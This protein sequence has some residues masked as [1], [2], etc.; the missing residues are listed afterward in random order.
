MPLAAPQMVEDVCMT[1][2]CEDVRRLRVGKQ[3]R[4]SQPIDFSSI[5]LPPVH[6]QSPP[7]LPTVK[8]A[9]E[10]LPVPAP[11]P[12]QRWDW[13]NDSLHALNSQLRKASN[14]NK[15]WADSTEMLL[16]QV[17]L[18][19]ADKDKAYGAHKITA[20]LVATTFGLVNVV[21]FLCKAGVDIN[22]ADAFGCTPL[23]LAVKDY[24]T[25]SYRYV[26]SSNF[27][28]MLLNVGA[29]IY[30]PTKS[31]QTPLHWAAMK[32]SEDCMRH[33]L[34]GVVDT[35]IVDKHGRTA[36]HYAVVHAWPRENCA[37]AP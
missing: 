20:L 16:Q 12:K 25:F 15:R 3:Q 17:I 9:P 2:V 7:S 24:G 19:G 33:L 26:D 13:S 31:G 28:L 30:M 29:D 8:A 36:L 32:T 14:G 23:H 34:K 35:D 5:S 27:L 18:A 37:D 21:D 22:K 11:P 10:N 6:F 4:T 1:D